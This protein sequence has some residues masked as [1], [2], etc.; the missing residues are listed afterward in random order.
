MS[1]K[2]DGNVI[3]FTVNGTEYHW[4]QQYITGEQIKNLAQIPL[5]TDLYLTVQEPWQDQLIKNNDTVDVARNG[6]EQFFTKQ[7]LPYSIDGVNYLSDRQFISGRQIRHQGNI[8]PNKE[9]FLLIEEPWED[10]PVD[11]HDLINLALPG[12]EKFISKDHTV[13]I[14]LIVNGEPKEYTGK[15]ITFKQVVLLAYPV[16][17]PSPNKVYTVVYK[18]GPIQNPQ[19][20]MVEGQTIRVK[21]KMIFNV[22]ETTKS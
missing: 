9:I 13:S 22:T 3:P 11:N 6:I 20:S 1:F 10:E 16:Y 14:I 17:D 8:P 5:E 19:G 2:D 21:N 4:N 12:K 18:R 15:T 7:P